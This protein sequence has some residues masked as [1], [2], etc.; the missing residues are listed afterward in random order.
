MRAVPRKESIAMIL[1]ASSDLRPSHLCY[2][3][4]KTASISSWKYHCIE[5]ESGARRQTATI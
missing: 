3:A 4:A 5:K 1:K 2:G